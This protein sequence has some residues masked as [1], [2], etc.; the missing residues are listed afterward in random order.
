MSSKFYEASKQLQ[1]LLIDRDKNG[2]GYTYINQPFLRRMARLFKTVQ[3]VVLR[4]WVSRNIEI[5]D[6]FNIE[7][8]TLPG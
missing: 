8:Q 5:K 1:R 7:I 3:S 4:E 2:A 6:K